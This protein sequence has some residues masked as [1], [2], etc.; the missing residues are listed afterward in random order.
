GPV[1]WNWRR[2][3]SL[4]KMNA[5]LT[6]PT[7]KM[8]SPLAGAI[9]PAFSILASTAN[10]QILEDRVYPSWSGRRERFGQTVEGFVPSLAGAPRRT[11]FEGEGLMHGELGFPVIVGEGHRRHRFVARF[12]VAG[13]SQDDALGRHDFAIDAV[14]PNVVPL[15]R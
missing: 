15:G 3:R 4:K 2:L 5:P 14:H 1:M 9:G 11:G 8:M 10:R 6:V 12:I 7:I 13:T